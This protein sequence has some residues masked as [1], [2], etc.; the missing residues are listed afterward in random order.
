M[1]GKWGAD[2]PDAV[3]E[4][5]RPREHGH[6]NVIAFFHIDIGTMKDNLL[7]GPLLLPL[8]IHPYLLLTQKH[9]PALSVLV[10]EKQNQKEG[11]KSQ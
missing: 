8:L 1:G 6:G 10:P 11:Y 5:H 4:H 2:G 7:E 3:I 9:F